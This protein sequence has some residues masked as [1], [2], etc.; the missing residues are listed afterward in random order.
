LKRVIAEVESAALLATVDRHVADGS[1]LVSS[2]LA[3]IEVTRA[4]AARFEGPASATIH[5]DVALSG[6]A[7]LPMSA[8][9][10][11]HARRVGAAELRSQEAVNLASALLLDAGEVVTY[12]DGLAAACV[13]AG[14]VV[15]AP[16]R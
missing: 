11:S 13:G 2:S 8:E 9:D 14:L 5:A 15:A 3:W 1:L 4:L 10:G 6:V 7:E 12:D 16:G